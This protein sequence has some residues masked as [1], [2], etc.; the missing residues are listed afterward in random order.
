MDTLRDELPNVLKRCINQARFVMDVISE[1]LPLDKWALRSPTDLA[2]ACVL[3][4][5]AMVP[6]LA[7][8]T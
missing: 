3:V 1:V 5:E 8:Q 7:D 2:C 4:L 6:A